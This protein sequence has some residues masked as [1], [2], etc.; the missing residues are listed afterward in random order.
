MALAEN[1]PQKT[2]ERLSAYLRALQELS[3]EGKIFASSTDIGRKSGI[4]AE[5]VRKDMSAFGCPGRRGLGYN[6]DRLADA[7]REIL[8]VDRRWKVA[9]VGFGMLGQSL[10]RYKGFADSGFDITAV[11]EIDKVLVGNDFEGI[12]IHAAE[13]MPDVCE[14]DTILL[15]IVAV[16]AD[17]AFEAFQQC[18]DA[19]IRGIL[20]F[21]D[22]TG[23]TPPPHAKILNVNIAAE[24]EALSYFL[25]H[26]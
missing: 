11:F 20:N 12:P 19:G 15:A 2:I 3:L 8:G 13:D 1:T 6:A 21:T 23:F 18:L 25:V 17:R 4:S 24:M 26:N 9:L 10:I 5:L 7:I 22:Q 14:R 16:P